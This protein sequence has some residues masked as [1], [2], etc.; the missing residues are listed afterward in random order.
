MVQMLLV[1][2]LLI[3]EMNYHKVMNDSINYNSGTQSLIENQ[4]GVT[5][6]FSSQPIANIKHK[7]GA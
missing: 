4:Q 1:T 2:A 6:V 7:I 3:V 5:T